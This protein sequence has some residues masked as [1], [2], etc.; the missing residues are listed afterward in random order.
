[1]RTV[2]ILRPDITGGEVADVLSRELGPDCNVSVVAT[3]EPAGA[4]TVLVRRGSS[5]FWLAQV[6]IVR[7]LDRT[8]LSVSAGGFV[9]ERLIGHFGIAR[10]VMRVLRLSAELRMP[11]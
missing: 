5:R 2:T 3:I 4:D 6:G 10:K 9:F 7:E 1:M 8:R 11:A